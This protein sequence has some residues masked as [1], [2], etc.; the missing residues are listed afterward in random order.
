[1][2]KTKIMSNI[3]VVPTPIKIGESTLKA[4]DD[5]IY[6]GQTIQLGKSNFEKEVNRR[7]QLGW[8]AFGKPRKIF[9]SHIPQCL[10]TKAFDQCVLP[11]MTY[12]SE[13]WSFTIGLIRRLKVTQSAMERA[14]AEAGD[15]GV[16][17]A[18]REVRGWQ[19]EPRGLAAPPA[20]AALP[21]KLIQVASAP[22][23]SRHPQSCSRALGQLTSARQGRGGAR[24]AP[25]QCRARR[26]SGRTPPRCPRPHRRLLL[27]PAACR[28]LRRHHS[29]SAPD[30]PP[31]VMVRKYERMSG[32]Q[33]WSEEEMAKAVAAVV[34]GKMGYKLAARTY[35]IPRSTLQ[36][37]ASKVRYQQPD[38][39]KPLMGHYRRVFTES[40]EKDLVGYIK[41]MEKFFMG[42]SRRDIRELAFQYAEDNNLN[43][44]FDVNT[45]MAGEDWVRNFLKRN[46]ELL[47]KSEK[48]YELEP[49][50]FDQFYHFMCQS[51]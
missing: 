23:A 21:G 48:D 37:R 43:H 19:P 4:I 7:I 5:Y 27:T 50:N 32:R 45:R 25:R 46:P 17:G 49:V 11:V 16:A 34:S 33:S 3:Y 41:S 47:H 6:L 40:Q 42:V 30:A 24:R 29:P 31:T 2:D 28:R 8:A 12:G 10:K 44:P 1:M 26:Q 39:P 20:R 35:H 14:D 15:G 38:D 22:R 9:S 36:R 18:A 51:S 13:T